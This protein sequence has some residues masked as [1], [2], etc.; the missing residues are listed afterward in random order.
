MVPPLRL[1]PKP[2]ATPNP[3]DRKEGYRLY[4]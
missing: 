3:G 2:S 1:V 4:G